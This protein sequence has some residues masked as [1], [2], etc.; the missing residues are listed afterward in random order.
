MGR[1]PPPREWSHR[2]PSTR[3]EPAVSIRAYA[4]EKCRIGNEFL[5]GTFRS[6]GDGHVIIALVW[7]AFADVALGRCVG[8][9]AP[10]V[11]G[12]RVSAERSDS[13]FRGTG[14]GAKPDRKTSANR[15]F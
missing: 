3:T 4:R 13:G 9:V 15:A 5:I 14:S 8:R 10:P 12:G 6:I 2:A 7:V 11:I 1:V